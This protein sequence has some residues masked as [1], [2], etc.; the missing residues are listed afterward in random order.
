[1]KSIIQYILSFFTRERYFKSVSLVSFW[2]KKTS[3]SKKV[4][5]AL[6]VKLGNTKIG[7]YSR[8]RH[9]STIYHAEIGNF[10]AIGRNAR[11]GIARHPT[12]LLSTN[13]I[14]YKKNQIYNKWARPIIFEEFKKTKIG[15][16]VWIGE[17]VMILGGVTIG[18]GAVIAARSVVTKDVPPYAIVGGVPAKI[19]KYRFN[20]EIIE[21]LLNTKWWDLPDSEIEKRLEI[22]TVFNISTEQI[23]MYF[24]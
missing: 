24:K 4:Y 9:L 3:F 14:F 16:D 15:N 17:S 22:F 5:I 7:K 19:L 21:T 1:M 18:D 12:N 20:E 13:L 10:S 23:N 8:I 11:I 2:D 6:G